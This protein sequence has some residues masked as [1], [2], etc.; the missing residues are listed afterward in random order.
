MA[1]ICEFLVAAGAPSRTHRKANM[2]SQPLYYPR[3]DGKIRRACQLSELL[4]GANFTPAELR[5]M[6]VRRTGT[7]EWVPLVS[8]LDSDL[9][10]TLGG[11]NG[12]IGF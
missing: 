5:R 9:A 10:A 1:G 7:E 2:S 6:E 12:V 11:S 3:L 4:Q 8:L